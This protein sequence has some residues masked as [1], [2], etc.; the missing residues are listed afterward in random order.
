MWSVHLSHLPFRLVM[1][2]PLSSEQRQSNARGDFALLETSPS[3]PS[4]SSTSDPFY[5]LFHMSFIWC[6]SRRVPWK[7][8]QDWVSSSHLLP[9]PVNLVPLNYLQAWKIIFSCVWTIDIF[10]N[11]L[12]ESFTYSTKMKV[13]GG[14]P[15]NWSKFIL[16][17]GLP[18]WLRW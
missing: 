6:F 9:P 4:L 14:L 12:L 3:Y 11:Y 7:P 13:E 5:C 10:G 17:L 2:H 8:V 18:W 15:K 16:Y 1:L